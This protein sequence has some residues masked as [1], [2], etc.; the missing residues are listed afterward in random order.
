MKVKKLT[1][2]SKNKEFAFFDD[3]SV[4]HKHKLNSNELEIQGLKQLGCEE[5]YYPCKNGK[6]SKCGKSIFPKQ[7]NKQQTKLDEQQNEIDKWQRKIGRARILAKKYRN[8]T[9]R[10]DG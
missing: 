3:S 2:Y 9:N 6:C 7:L 1:H 8:P 4:S 5:A 10:K